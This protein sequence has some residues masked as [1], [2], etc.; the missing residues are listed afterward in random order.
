MEGVLINNK[1][2][3]I[4]AATHVVT[5][6]LMCGECGGIWTVTDPKGNPTCPK[7]QSCLPAWGLPQ[8]YLGAAH[9]HYAARTEPDT[10]QVRDAVTG[11]SL[12]PS[13]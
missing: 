11:R 4:L 10:T 5:H 13:D 2:H 12:G 9:Q 3:T 8:N 1:S 7:C 6:S